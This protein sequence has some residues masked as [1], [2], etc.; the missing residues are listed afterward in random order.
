LIT[1][2][3]RFGM[4]TPA[5]YGLAKYLTDGEDLVFLCPPE[6]INRD[7]LVLHLFR[8]HLFPR[9]YPAHSLFGPRREPPHDDAILL[10]KECHLY[11]ARVNPEGVPHFQCCQPI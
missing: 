5:R 11:G 7:Q 4:S 1:P 6:E 9:P 8:K 10:T 3:G 2:D